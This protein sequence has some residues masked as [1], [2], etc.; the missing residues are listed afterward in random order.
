M[1]KTIATLTPAIDM[2]SEIHV[3]RK[4][5]G[6]SSPVTSAIMR[7]MILGTATKIKAPMAQQEI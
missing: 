1:K 6:F 4:L 7:R 5:N 3:I 2:L